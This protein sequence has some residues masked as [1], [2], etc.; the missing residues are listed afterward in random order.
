MTANKSFRKKIAHFGAFDHDS[1][2]DL[3]FPHIVEYFFPEFEIIHVSP[4]GRDTPWSDAKK[5]ISIEEAF[6]ITDWDGI[7]VGGGDIVQITEGFIWNESAIQS[8]GALCSL[9]SGA[10]LLSAELGIP[11][12]WNGP[13]VPHELPD[14]LLSMAQKS[15]GCVDYLSV[16]DKF[17]E[18]RIGKLTQKKVNIVPDTALL[19]SQIWERPQINDKIKKPLVLSLTPNDI[20]NKLCEIDLLI[21]KVIRD[22]R[23]SDEVIVLPLMRWLTSSAENK[24]GHL[25]QKYNLKIK[26]QNLTLRECAKEIAIAGGYVGNS[27]H[28]LITA[29]SYGI[30]AVHVHPHGFNATTKYAGFANIIKSENKILATSYIEASD[31]ILS[32]IRNDISGSVQSI[33]EHFTKI[34]QT[35]N[36]RADTKKEIWKE[37]TNTAYSET[38]NLLM[39]GYSPYHLL[40]NRKNMISDFINQRDQ[41]SSA[42]KERDEKISSLSKAVN[43]FSKS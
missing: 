29:I 20:D 3:I 9:W 14:S 1:Y 21:E 37:I 27:L 25:S 24:L 5:T 28:G 23:F 18:T 36:K 35:L 33:N 2:G 41:L 32:N 22:N 4:S 42:L 8:L 6:N 31:F 43:A 11:C 34:R 16:R 40:E 15:I 12:A 7:L 17:S 30:P 26:D 13:G 10:S 19:I 39:H 38:R